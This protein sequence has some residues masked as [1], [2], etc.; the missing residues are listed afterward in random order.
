MNKDVIVIGGGIAGLA[1]G[2]YAR[3]NGFG[4]VVLEQQATPGGMCAA[5]KRGEY[6]FDGCIHWLTGSAPG[7]PFYKFWEELGAVKGARMV[8]HESFVVVE[9]GKG[10]KLFAYADADRLE[11]HMKEIS[12]EDGA[13]AE[14]F[15]G[16]V[17]KMATMSFPVEKA[18]ET[19]GPLDFLK[20]GLKMAPYMGLMKKLGSLTA[21]QWAAG[22][23]SPVLR[24]LF[25]KIMGDYALTGLVMVLAG[26]HARSSGYPIGGSRPF[27]EAIVARL[28]ALGGKIRYG[29]KVEK[30]LV[31]GGK[32]VGVRLA[33]GEELRADYVISASDLR[34]TVYDFLGGK[35]VEPQHERY[36]REVPISPTA[37][38]VS[39]G[40]KM[41][42]SGEPDVVTRL[43]KL[44]APRT[45]GGSKVEWFP[46]KLYSFDPTLAPKGST[47]VVALIDADYDH[48]NELS[49]D[50]A[51]YGAAKEQVLKEVAEVFESLYPGFKAA[52]E[53]SDVVT[54]HTYE[55]YTSNYRGSFMTWMAAPGQGDMVIKKTLPGLEGLYLCGQWLMAPGGLPCAANT[56]RDVV[57]MICKREGR[58]FRT[59]KA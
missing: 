56:A 21:G 58:K 25:P 22:F 46:S 27:A 45:I 23:K 31:E 55:R 2:C 29:A 10:G 32:A 1:A 18:V 28:G 44:P 53:E 14:E 9:D 16:W 8:D 6:T 33:G 11:A 24:E 48:W 40:V 3:M 43:V 49:K 17:R 26:F 30:V 38:Q 42:L 35:Y 36:F 41:D 13:M 59:T 19:M 4:A 15:C 7:N 52:I 12:P 51:A 39:F 50:R 34:R 54:P 37:L 57:Q 20:V 5:W 47:V